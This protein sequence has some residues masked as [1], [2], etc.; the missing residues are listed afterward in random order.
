LAEQK[1]LALKVVEMEM[2]LLA[3]FIPERFK[4][5]FA[6]SGRVGKVV[7]VFCIFHGWKILPP[8]AGRPMAE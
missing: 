5:K 6:R 8:L 2:I 7:S 3:L 1:S 4:A